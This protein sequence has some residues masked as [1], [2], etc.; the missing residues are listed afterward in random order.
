M[1]PEEVQ[2][3]FYNF[4]TSKGMAKNAI[5]GVMGNISNECDWDYEQQEVGGGGYG[6]IQ[7]TGERRTQLEAYGI[8]L[9]CQEEFF[10]S[11]LTGSGEHGAKNQWIDSHGY[12]YS[13]FMNGN[14]SP[15]ESALA[16][17]YCFERPN[18]S[19]ADIEKRKNEATRFSEMDWGSSGGGS[20]GGGGTEKVIKL[21]R[22]PLW[23]NEDSLFGNWFN[24]PNNSS[25]E[26]VRIM[27]N[28]ATIK[29]NGTVYCINKKYL[30]NTT[31]GGGST[32]GSNSIIDKA[33]EWALDTAN[34]DSYG[35]SQDP[36]LRWGNGYYD[37]SSF[38][39]TA[40]RNA[41]L[42][43]EGATYTG[44]MKEV[45]LNEGF[46]DVTDTIDLETGNGLQKGD[47]LLN[48]VHHTEL[49]TSDNKMVGART[50]RLPQAEQI[51]EHSYNNYPWDIV[52][53]YK[54]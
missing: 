46:E 37:C 20:G 48:I 13:S 35:Y 11:E 28:K 9:E 31:Q 12:N 29:C 24:N 33:I 22:C 54:K 42:S 44:N 14:Y 40:Y 6:L 50:D 2:Q 38:V 8:T 17:M 7:W 21:K 51:E 25:V 32:G 5:F 36:N 45:F 30:K 19:V 43:L 47:V 26:I 18:L 41:G 16:F 3:H 49:Y 23:G 39:I 27:G 52:L 4:C 10:Y 34:D 15:S 1:T 53:R